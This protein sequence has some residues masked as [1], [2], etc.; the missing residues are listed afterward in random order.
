LR[1]TKASSERQKPEKNTKT[2][3]LIRTVAQQPLVAGFEKLKK[4]GT[5][6]SKLPHVFSWLNGRLSSYLLFLFL[7]AD[8]S[9][10]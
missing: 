2:L 3:K 6:R 7:I 9:Q 10:C 5:N 1:Q 8:L 4:V